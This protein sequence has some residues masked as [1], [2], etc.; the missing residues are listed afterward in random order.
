MK[1]II[2]LTAILLA[3]VSHS[4]A[5]L[6]L[7]Q[8]ASQGDLERVKELIEKEREDVNKKAGRLDETP[9]G[10]AAWSGK[11]EVVNYLLGR[12]DIEVNIKN[13]NGSTT[14]HQMARK[15]GADVVGKLLDHKDIVV[16]AV[17][18]DNQTPLHLHFGWPIEGV[19]RRE[20]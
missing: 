9:L 3:S 11:I 16:D 18:R 2:F 7:H 20:T 4:Y 8:A 5:L 19:C 12:E 15:G 13:N 6:S 17:N 10:D 1:R 14:L